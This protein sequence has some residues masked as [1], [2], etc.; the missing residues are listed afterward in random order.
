[1]DGYPARQSLNTIGYHRREPPLYVSDQRERTHQL[2]PQ[3][4][5]PGRQVPPAI[6]G[7]IDNESFS[8]TVVCSFASR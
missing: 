7:M 6:E 1:M 3:A 2:A 4:Q 8:L 5:L